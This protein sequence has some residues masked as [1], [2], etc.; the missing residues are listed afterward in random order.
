MKEHNEIRNDSRPRYR[1][2]SLRVIKGGKPFKDV[3]HHRHPRR[4]Y[5]HYGWRPTLRAYSLQKLVSSHARHPDLL[6]FSA[7][8][9]SLSLSLSSFFLLSLA[10]ISRGKEETPAI[11]TSRSS[12]RKP[13]P[14]PREKTAERRTRVAFH[15]NKEDKS[16]SVARN[17][18]MG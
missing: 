10:E 4:G 8:S 7:T 16:V 15:R 1:D 11:C 9:L 3:C 5:Y 2:F 6:S 12:K 13:R 18:R 17:M 14:A